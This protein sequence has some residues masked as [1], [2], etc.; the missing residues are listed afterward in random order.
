MPLKI[1][2]AARKSM[3]EVAA[4]EAAKRK[5]KRPVV[6][7]NPYELKRVCNGP[8]TDLPADALARIEVEVFAKSAE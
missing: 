4:A 6:E 8:R 7:A 5:N 3:A 2:V 1:D